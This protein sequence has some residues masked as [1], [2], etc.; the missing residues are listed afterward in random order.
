MLKNFWISR[1][2]QLKWKIKKQVQEGQTARKS[3]EIVPHPHPPEKILLRLGSKIFFIKYTKT[4]ISIKKSAFKKLQECG[5]WVS[6]NGA[7]Q[8]FFLTPNRNMFAE[9]LVLKSESFLAVLREHIILN[10]KWSEVHKLSEVFW[11]KMYCKIS[12]LYQ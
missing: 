6:R 5:F 11:A 1:K 7:V 4:Y 2:I 12:D 9:K 10:S 3:K 8:M